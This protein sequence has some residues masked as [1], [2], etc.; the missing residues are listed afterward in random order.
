[1]LHNFYVTTSGNFHTQALNATLAELG[2]DRVLFSSDFPFE[3]MREAA[4]WFDNAAI[5]ENDRQD[6]PHERQAPASRL[7]GADRQARGHRASLTAARLA[8][9]TAGWDRAM[10]LTCVTAPSS[11]IPSASVSCL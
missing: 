9:P 4:D 8:Q 5:S 2:A 7:A 1:M 11:P 10:Y 6:R 3:S